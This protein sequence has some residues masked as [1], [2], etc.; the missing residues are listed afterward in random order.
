M[1]MMIASM[2]QMNQTNQPLQITA[3][4][5]EYVVRAQQDIL[6]SESDWYK[7]EINDQCFESLDYF[8]GG[9]TGSWI[10]KRLWSTSV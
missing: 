3:G 10:L 8:A 6:L 5:E 1:E 7:G 9:L 2:D 4:L